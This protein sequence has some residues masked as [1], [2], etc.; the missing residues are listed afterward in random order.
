MEEFMRILM[1]SAI[2]SLG[3]GRNSLL[4]SRIFLTFHFTA[5]ST[6]PATRVASHFQINGTECRGTRSWVETEVS[7]KAIKRNCEA[8]RAKAN[9]V[10]L[11]SPA[12]YETFIDFTSAPTLN[13]SLHHFTA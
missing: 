8:S 2:I 10:F 1:D 7:H 12:H 6:S 3:R 4:C 5:L 13:S 11:S 9:L